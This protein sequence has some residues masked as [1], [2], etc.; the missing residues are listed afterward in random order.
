MSITPEERNIKAKQY[1]EDLYA[2]ISHLTIV[3]FSS[4]PL[5]KKS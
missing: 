1:V 5:F 2:N 3:D 4:H